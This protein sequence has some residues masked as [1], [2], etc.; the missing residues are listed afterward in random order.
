MSVGVDIHVLAMLEKQLEALREPVAAATLDGLAATTALPYL[1]GHNVG[2]LKAIKDIE[3]AIA[4]TR[5]KL[6]E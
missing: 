2:Y 6:L 3:D 1:Y 4:D 5:K